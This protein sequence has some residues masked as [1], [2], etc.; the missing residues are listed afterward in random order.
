MRELQEIYET[1]KHV[2]KMEKD[3]V[4]SMKHEESKAFCEGMSEAYKI[5]ADLVKSYIH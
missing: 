2:S 5:A 1:L 4:E 3:L